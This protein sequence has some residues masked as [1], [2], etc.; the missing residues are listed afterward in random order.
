MTTTQALGRGG[1]GLG[2]RVEV[3]ADLLRDPRA[4]DFVEVVAE[5]CFASPAARREAIALARVWPV[6]P[7]GVKLSLGS[8]EGIEADRARRLGELA[9]ELGAPVITEHVAFV[10]AGGR[11]IGHL[12]QVP[13]TREAL[14][15]VTRNVAA[16]RR[17]L[18]DVPLL[19]ENAAW[20]FRWPDDEIEEGAFYAEVAER[21]GCDLLLD[22]GNLYANARNAGIDPAALLDRYP[23]PRVR[24]IHIAGGFEEDGFYFDTHANAVPDEVFALLARAVAR[25]GPVPVVLERDDAFPPFAEIKTEMDRARSAAASTSAVGTEP[26]S[27]RMAP[28]PAG[29]ES[30]T[31]ESLERETSCTRDAM[32]RNQAFVAQMLTTMEE[33]S[34][35]E[36]R[37]FGERAITRSREIL[38]RKRVDDALPLLVTLLPHRDALKDIARACLSDA[39]RAPSLAGVTDAMRIASKAAETPAL[40]A[41]AKRDLLLLRSRFAG[42]LESGLRPRTEPFIGKERLAGGR[43]IWAVKGVGAGAD[44]RIFE[45]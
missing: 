28:V 16:A 25:T 35:D 19:L 9:R 3:A 10:R 42:T 2:F 33:P 36:A 6:V 20:T 8:A 44:I 41:A 22:L 21:T 27:A 13:F 4:A 40:A 38:R 26:W 37:P 11:E 7:H 32:E 5:A 17:H 12:T 34:A 14:R 39:P 30:S 18:P 43:V 24:M 15:V 31:R 1:V 23:L 45:R 29:S